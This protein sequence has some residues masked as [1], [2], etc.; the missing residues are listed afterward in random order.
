M[1][2]GVFKNTL[3]DVGYVCK[4]TLPSII[5]GADFHIDHGLKSGRRH[6]FNF[7]CQGRAIVTDIIMEQD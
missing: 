1:I 6:I 3:G 5:R 4:L 2:V 7:R